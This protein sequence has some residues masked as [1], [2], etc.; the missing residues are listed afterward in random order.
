M[1]ETKDEYYV[2]VKVYSRNHDGPISRYSKEVRFKKKSYTTVRCT[3]R[4]TVLLF[5]YR[6]NHVSVRVHVNMTGHYNIRSLWVSVTLAVDFKY[7]RY[8][9]G[10]L[11]GAQTQR[12]WT[13]YDVLQ[14]ISRNYNVIVGR[15]RGSYCQAHDRWK[16]S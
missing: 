14:H 1:V 16:H 3:R 11:L 13:C 8:T 7:I 5:K 12:Q 15:H 6:F 9:L 4:S 2:G 10:S